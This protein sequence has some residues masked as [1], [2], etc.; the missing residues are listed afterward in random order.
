MRL[1]LLEASTPQPSVED[2]LICL[3]DLET[4]ISSHL[5]NAYDRAKNSE[6]LEIIEMQPGA[7]YCNEGTS[8]LPVL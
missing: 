3:N 1:G 8:I 6:T 2:I 5:L 7:A 4:L